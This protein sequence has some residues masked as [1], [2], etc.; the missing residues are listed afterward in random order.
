MLLVVGSSGGISSIEGEGGSVAARVRQAPLTQQG[1]HAPFIVF[2]CVVQYPGGCESFPSGAVH[3]ARDN[4]ASTYKSFSVK[5]RLSLFVQLLR[6]HENEGKL[7]VNCE[8]S[9]A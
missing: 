4:D 7:S 9:A 3:T 6:N 8:K 2:P 1:P 5:S